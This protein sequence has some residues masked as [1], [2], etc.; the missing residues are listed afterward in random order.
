L[1]GDKVTGYTI[2]QIQQALKDKGYDPGPVDNILGSRTK[3]ALTKFQ[4][5]KNLPVG[6]L[7]LDTLKALGVKY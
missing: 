6:N 4:K 7:D 5:E 2:R 1:C 3:A